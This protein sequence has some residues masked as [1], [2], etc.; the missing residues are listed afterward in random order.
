MTDIGLCIT[1]LLDPAAN[2]APSRRVVRQMHGQTAAEVEEILRWSKDGRPCCGLEEIASIMG[3][4]I[5]TL[6]TY[7]DRIA[8]R[9]G[10][11]GKG[12]LIAWAIANGLA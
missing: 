2:T 7:R 5:S 9:H 10:V 4:G 11:K 3:C 12:A 8:E 1:R 6:R